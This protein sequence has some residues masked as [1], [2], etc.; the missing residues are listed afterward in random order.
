MPNARQP[1]LGVD[2]QQLRRKES[3]STTTTTT[4]RARLDVLVGDLLDFEGDPDALGVGA[5]GAAVED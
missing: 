1:L 2:L 5:E 4:T 3:T